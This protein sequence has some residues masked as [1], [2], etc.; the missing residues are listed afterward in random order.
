[1]I[2]RPNDAA[3][4]TSRLLIVQMYGAC[5]CALT[6][7]SISASSRSRM[8]TRS[9]PLK[10]WQASTFV[11]PPCEAGGGFWK[12]PWCSSS[13]IASTPRRFSRGTSALTV[14]ASSRKSSPAT[15]DGR[16]DERRALER[17]AD[18]C[19]PSPVEVV[20]IW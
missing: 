8:S 20:T 17:L 19:D 15:P 16:H 5:V 7:T 12:P 6:T 1:M 3:L 11:K 18:E 4:V 14:S 9:G 2:S 13:T 10:F